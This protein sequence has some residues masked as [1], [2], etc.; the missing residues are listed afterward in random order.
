MLWGL[1]FAGVFAYYQSGW[2]PEY[3]WL[4]LGTVLVEEAIG[5]ARELGAVTFDFLRGAE[6]Y[7]YRFGA[8]DRIDST[9]LIPRGLPGSLLQLKARTRAVLRSQAEGQGANGSGARNLLSSRRGVMG[10]RSSV[11]RSPLT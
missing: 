9:I 11:S 3:R 1:W 7:K 2:L 6:E 5:I 10:D 4:N 8:T